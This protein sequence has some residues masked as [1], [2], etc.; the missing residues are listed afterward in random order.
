MSARAPGQ[1]PSSHG[2]RGEWSNDVPGD[3][4]RGRWLLVWGAHGRASRARVSLVHMGVDITVWVALYNRRLALP[5][6]TQKMVETC[7]GRQSLRCYSCQSPGLDLPAWAA[8][9]AEERKREPQ[10]SQ[11]LCPCTGHVPEAQP[12][13]TLMAIPKGAAQRSSPAFC[14]MLWR[15][16]QM[17]EALR[18]CSPQGAVVTAGKWH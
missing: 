17:S 11:L 13:L 15:G 6:A 16:P 2:C 9:P 3:T 1:W 5:A 14:G 7:P 4:E 10:R 8:C 12:A 18:N